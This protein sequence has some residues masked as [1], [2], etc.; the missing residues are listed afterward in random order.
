[1]LEKVAVF[2]DRYD[3]ANGLIKKLVQLARELS[4]LSL[5]RENFVGEGCA[6]IYV[7]MV[8]LH[9]ASGALTGKADNLLASKA[10]RVLSV[11]F[12]D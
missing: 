1:M 5:S 4:K 6:W 11:G 2:D 8:D 12:R 3:A 7:F 10:C 9:C